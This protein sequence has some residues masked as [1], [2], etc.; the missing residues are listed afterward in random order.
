MG[1]TMSTRTIA[2]PESHAEHR[3]SLQPEVYAETPSDHTQRWSAISSPAVIQRTSKKPAVETPDEQEIDALLAE[4][5]CIENGR[6]A[7]DNPNASQILSAHHQSGEQETETG[8]A[9]LIDEIF[10]NQLSEAR[11]ISAPSERV[12]ALHELI[13]M[14][15]H[16]SSSKRAGARESIT[17]L[18][19]VADCSADTERIIAMLIEEF[20]AEHQPP[21]KEPTHQATEALVHSLTTACSHFP[22]RTRCKTL[23]MQLWAAEKLACHSMANIAMDMFAA[24]MDSGA[25]DSATEQLL[26]A[27][28][29]LDRAPLTQ[30][31]MLATTLY[32]CVPDH[33]PKRLECLEALAAKDLRLPDTQEAQSFGA[34]LNQ[35]IY[36]L[37]ILTTSLSA[38]SDDEPYSDE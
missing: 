17:A 31:L 26:V 2:N 10:D 23:L 28:E 9:A 3:V 1:D 21:R 13:R 20:I 35:Q 33:T 25:T 8:I 36:E 27:A 34:I 7:A 38:D 30:R 22:I 18:I 12:P 16:L 15:A 6:E 32:R 24:A 5:R 37:R 4:L 14:L 11:A 19:G 29:Y